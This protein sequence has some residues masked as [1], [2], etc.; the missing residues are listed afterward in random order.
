MAFS[1]RARSLEFRRCPRGTCPPEVRVAIGGDN[2]SPRLSTPCLSTP[3]LS[4]EKGTRVGDRA[5]AGNVGTARTRAT[6]SLLD[7]VEAR[8]T[9]PRR[10]TLDGTDRAGLRGGA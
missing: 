7:R 3:R 8:F 4:T 9:V 10:F 1:A 5:A 2:L 6:S